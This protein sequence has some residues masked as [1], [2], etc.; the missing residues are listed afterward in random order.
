MDKKAKKILMQ[1]FWTS[2]GWR[3]SHAPFS[4]DDFEYA[5]SHGLMFD[6][7]TI[8]H[9]ELISR[10]KELHAIIPKERVAAAFLH[11]LST[12]KVYLR[13]A[14]SSWALTAEL[15][16]HTYGEQHV[17]HPSYS[18]CGH[19]NSKKLLSDADY[20]NADLNVLNFERVKWGGIRL[21]HLLY[22]WLDLELLS[23]EEEAAVQEEDVSILKNLL[24]AAESCSEHEGPRKLEKRWKDS[25]ASSKN[26]RDV[27]MEVLGFAGVLAAKDTPRTRK[28]WDSDF[29]SMAVWQGSDEYSRERA[30]HFFGGFY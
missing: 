28:G 6:P 9:D 1:T 25:L 20:T 15:P 4:G 2:Q 7:L 10:L 27:L 3:S 5:K 22:C 14:L 19:C 18:S 11:S 8:R 21:N 16:L 29:V 30:N 23:R 26:E 13:S 12:R 17:V 24:Q